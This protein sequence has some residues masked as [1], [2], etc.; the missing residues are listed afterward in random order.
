[1]CPRDLD[2]Q[3]DYLHSYNPVNKQ[4]QNNIIPVS[5]FLTQSGT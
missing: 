1:M 4:Q 3:M 2:H 5:E